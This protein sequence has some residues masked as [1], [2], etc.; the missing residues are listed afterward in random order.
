M[1]TNIQTIIPRFRQNISTKLCE[2]QELLPFTDGG[3]DLDLLFMKVRG[4]GDVGTLGQP[5]ILP[6]VVCQFCFEGFLVV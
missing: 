3:D 4:W 2:T 5:V 1:I 6:L